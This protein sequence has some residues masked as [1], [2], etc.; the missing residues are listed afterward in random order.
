[1]GFTYRVRNRAIRAFLSLFARFLKSPHE[2]TQTIG[3]IEKMEKNARNA[4]IALIFKFAI[5]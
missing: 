2:N 1:M 5:V 3:L 4:L